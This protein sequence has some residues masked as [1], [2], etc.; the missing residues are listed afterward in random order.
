MKRWNMMRIYHFLMLLLLL[1]LLVQ[2]LLLLLLYP[3][4]ALVSFLSVVIRS[5]TPHTRINMYCMRKR[6]CP[7]MPEWCQST[8]EW[9]RKACHL[10]YIMT[11]SNLCASYISITSSY[12]EWMMPG[13]LNFVRAHTC[14]C[15]V[16]AVFVWTPCRSPTS[17]APKR[18]GCLMAKR[19]NS[20]CK[21]FETSL[22]LSLSQSV[23]KGYAS[24]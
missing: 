5:Y 10:Q 23:R 24:H 9:G 6:V 14:Q 18:T 13:Y 21:A 3:L 7:S 12:S 4:Y 20:T 11:P 2:E 22:S 1:A 15:A 8:R 19:S 16:C 17:R